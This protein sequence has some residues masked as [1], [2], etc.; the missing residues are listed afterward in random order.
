MTSLLSLALLLSAPSEPIRFEIAQHI[1]LPAA[2]AEMKKARLWIP[3][4]IDTDGQSLLR[5]DVP[6]GGG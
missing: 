2:S 4:P 3:I 6:A 5:F 1:E